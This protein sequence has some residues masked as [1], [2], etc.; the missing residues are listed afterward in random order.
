MES[1]KIKA[2]GLTTLL[3]HSSRLS[4]PLAEG[5]REH[6]ALV[7][8][9]P[10]NE[11]YYRRV[12]RS[13]FELGMYFDKKLG[14][15]MPTDNIR[16]SIIE[17][18]RLSKLGTAIDRAVQILEEK[19]GLK[20]DGPRSI[21]GLWEAKFY[22]LSSVGNQSNRVMRCRPAFDSWSFEAEVFYDPSMI[23]RSQLIG[24]MTAAGKHIGIGDYRPKFGRYSVEV[25][26]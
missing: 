23:D 21:E 18:G 24:A 4:N 2:T 12:A 22:D 6:K 11:E 25:M 15:Y 5:M 9:K 10:K 1:L 20:Y 16:K 14:P 19:V 13:E 3:M 7:A 8:A 26:S 17:G